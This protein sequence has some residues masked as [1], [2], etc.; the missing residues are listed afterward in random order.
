MTL[1]RVNRL[2]HVVLLPQVNVHINAMFAAR[3]LSTNIISSSTN[4]FIGSLLVSLSTPLFIGLFF[5]ISGEK[6]FQ[7]KKCLKRFSHSGSYSTHMNKEIMN[8]EC[9]IVK[10]SV[11]KKSLVKE[12]RVRENNNEPDFTA[13]VSFALLQQ[14]RRELEEHSIVRLMLMSKCCVPELNSSFNYVNANPLLFANDRTTSPDKS[15]F[16]PT[17]DETNSPSGS[18][19]YTNGRIASPDK[20]QVSPVMKEN[21]SPSPSCSLPN[22]VPTESLVTNGKASSDNSQLSVTKEYNSASEDN[23]KGDNLKRPHND[24][25][26]TGDENSSANCE[27]LNVVTD[28]NMSVVRAY[29]QPLPSKLFRL[30]DMALAPEGQKTTT[31]LH[32]QSD[33]SGLFTCDQCDKTFNKQSSLARHKYEHSGK[34]HKRRD[35]SGL[36]I[37]AHARGLKHVLSIIGVRPHKC[38]VC[39]KAFKHKHHLTEHKRLHR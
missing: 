10:D 13:N 16:S 3:R 30:A 6:P 28:N 5:F 24:G 8:K 32:T 29:S 38:D 15:Q 4:G 33:A 27:E 12:S 9:S 36:S 37:F 11:V 2:R 26:D 23:E 7:C 39:S 19:F 31:D 34:C 18:L 21:N 14:Q 35:I 22:N 17:T 1:N 20:V 25:K